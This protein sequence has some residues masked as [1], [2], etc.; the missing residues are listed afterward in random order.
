LTM[1]DEPVVFGVRMVADPK[2]ALGRLQTTVRERGGWAQLFDA[3]AV[4]GRDHI[5]SA[6]H[7][8]E[9]AVAENR[10]TTGSLEM[11]I[12]LYVSG[13]RQIS[14]AIAA[15][16]ARPGRPA[17]AVISGPLGAQEV[18][19]A[20]GWERDDSLLEPTPARLQSAGFSKK[21]IEAAGGNATDLILERVARVDLIK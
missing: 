3:E 16:G 13:E 6:V 14:K 9:R 12:L 20:L 8:A 11:E 21:E 2:A 1:G 18:L 10:N 19:P 7:H 15:A 17:V 5:V 4:L